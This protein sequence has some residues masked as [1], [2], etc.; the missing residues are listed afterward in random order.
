LSGDELAER[1]CAR[2]GC[3]HE[4]HLMVPEKVS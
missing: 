4:P 3:A 2:F 1:V